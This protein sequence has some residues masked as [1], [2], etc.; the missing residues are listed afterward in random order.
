LTIGVNDEVTA[1]SQIACRIWIAQFPG[2]MSR[3]SPSPMTPNP[4]T[5]RFVLQLIHIFFATLIESNY[6]RSHMWSGKSIAT[7]DVK[8]VFQFVIPDG[9][10]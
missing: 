7:N 1:D 5:S 9:G 3:K 8:R 10:F 6:R 2:R 4:K